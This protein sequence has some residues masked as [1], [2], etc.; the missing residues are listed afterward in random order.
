MK[1]HF[2]DM[3]KIPEMRSP[4]D[5][6]KQVDENGESFWTSRELARTMG[7]ND[8]RNFERVMDKSIKVCNQKGYHSGEHFTLFTEMVQL[9]SGA[10]RRV[11]TYRLS[12]LACLVI[13]QN[14]DKKKPFVKL[15]QEY[16]SDKSSVGDIISSLE[17]N[18]FLYHSSA[19]KVSVAVVFNNETFWLS[20]KRMGEL[21]GVDIRTINY[22]LQ[23]IYVSKE[24]SDQTTIRKIEIVQQ[25][26]SRSVNRM[27][28]VYNLDAVIAVGYRVNSYEATQFRMWCA[29]VLKEF[30]LK[31]FVLDDERLK[32]T[33]V[34]GKD[35]FDELLERIREIR[36]SERRYYQKITDIY[37]ECSADYDAQSDSTKQFYKVV[38]NM[39]HWAVTHK[40]AAEIIYE[41]ADADKPHMGLMTWKHAPDG[42]VIKS[43]VTVAK[44]YLS[45][46]EVDSLNLLSNAFLDFAESMARRHILMTMKDWM[47]KLDDF[48]RLSDYDV[49]KD[50]GT[51]S[52]ESAQEKALDEYER[53]RL[54]QDQNFLSDFDK[55]IRGLFDSSNND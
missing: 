10:F 13:A 25:E 3:S 2:D 29:S 28:T 43:D 1:D 20:Q 35:Y 44:N 9:G 36:T 51:V 39:M 41:R 26:G 22:H 15:A 8:Y 24:L 38:Q 17:S 31:G 32:N 21:F 18:V 19:G 40:T 47:K 23:Q 53:F 45:E 55:E 46:S 4:F 50:A 34:F 52:H 27:I 48:L 7:Y 42:R 49:L 54:I 16:Y 14:A 37:A 5:E 12:G 6:I 11:E 30:M 33:N